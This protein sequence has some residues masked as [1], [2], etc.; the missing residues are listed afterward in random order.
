MCYEG[1]PTG[2][3]NTRCHA[4]LGQ[5]RLGQAR[6][7][8]AR[9]GQCFPLDVAAAAEPVF[10][11]DFVAA[12]VQPILAPVGDLDVDAPDPLRRP[13]CPLS[14][15]EILPAGAAQLRRGNLLSI[16]HGAT[17]PA[18]ALDANGPGNDVPGPPGW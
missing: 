1:R 15:G 8:Q 6:L 13:A 18:T 4:G 16:R 17:M 5:A 11:R 12:P 10:R 3:E 14:I 9:L 2:I 7:G